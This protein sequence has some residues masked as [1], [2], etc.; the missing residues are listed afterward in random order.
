[1]CPLEEMVAEALREAGIDFRREGDRGLPTLMLD[2]YLPDFDVY[3]EVKGGHTQ[4]V[5][6]QLASKPNV[7]VAQGQ[8]S[9]KF[10]AECL[11]S[12]QRKN[13]NGMG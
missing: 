13:M 5:L 12:F 11:R 1:M 9:V 6:R 7:I 8:T 3:I 4:R 2:F 10:L